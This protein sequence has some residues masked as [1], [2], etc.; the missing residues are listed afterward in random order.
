MKELGRK[1]NEEGRDY[2]RQ[3][4]AV[5]SLTE[6]TLRSYVSIYRSGEDARGGD[7]SSPVARIHHQALGCCPL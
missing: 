7:C 3:H 6:R 5:F 2:L 4:L 1:E